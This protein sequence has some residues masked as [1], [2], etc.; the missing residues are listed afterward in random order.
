MYRYRLRK[1]RIHT[2]GGKEH[3]A[4]EGDDPEVHGVEYVAAVKLGEL[5]LDVRAGGRGIEQSTNHKTIG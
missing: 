2:N 1:A 4:G 3:E 5:V